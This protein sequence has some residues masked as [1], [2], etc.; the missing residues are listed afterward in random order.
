MSKKLSD[1]AEISLGTILT[2]VKPESEL[3]TYKLF[4][5]ISMQE[6][7]YNCGKG[8]SGYEE[9]VSKIDEKKIDKC[10][11]TQES[12]V[13]IGLASQNAMVITKERANSLLPSNFCLVR[14][15]NQSALDP[16]FFTWLFNENVSVK[17]QLTGSMQGQSYVKMM[18]LDTIRNLQID[19]PPICKQKLIGKIYI[20]SIQRYHYDK[21]LIE[22]KQLLLNKQLE[23]KL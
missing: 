21:K 2:R 5:T 8:E 7:S 18:T 12:D 13:I 19:L 3:Q 4:S 22:L 14:I 10:L 11:L 9:I 1:L 20:S 6:L 15:A 16:F 23:N 17:Q